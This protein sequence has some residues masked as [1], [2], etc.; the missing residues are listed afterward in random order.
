MSAKKFLAD[1]PKLT[2]ANSY[3]KDGVIFY[4]VKKGYDGKP[5][6]LYVAYDYRTKYL[7]WFH[8]DK[9]ELILWINSH[10]DEIKFK[11]GEA[12]K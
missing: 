4:I 12:K 9:S 1:T 10:I 7:V 3:I 2:K 11:I 5:D 8:K 6:K